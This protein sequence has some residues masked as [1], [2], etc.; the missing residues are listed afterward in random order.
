M[1]TNF[2]KHFASMYEG[3]LIGAGSVVFAV[4]GY[5][6]ANQVPELVDGGERMVVTLNPRLLGMI[7]GD[8]EEAVAGAVKFLCR[9]DKG[10]NSKVE[11]GKRLVRLSEFDYWVVNGR[12]YRELGREER[13]REQN[14]AAQARFRLKRSAGKGVGSGDGREKRFVA[15]VEAG[16]EAEADRIVAEDLPGEVV[17]EGLPPDEG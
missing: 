7:L 15:A 12:F 11:D 8:G 17:D 14:R 16:D 3:S 2:G 1:N 9:P 6:I 13:K 4:M 10:S 5:V